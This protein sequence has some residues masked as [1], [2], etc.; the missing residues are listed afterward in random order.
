MTTNVVDEP[1]TIITKR[2]EFRKRN[3][4]RYEKCLK[5]RNDE[6]R[7]KHTKKRFNKT[8][9]PIAKPN[10]NTT[11]HMHQCI[12]RFF[13]QQSNIHTHYIICSH[14]RETS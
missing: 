7:S 5:F 10:H 4:M 13:M 3:E 14:M 2:F 12:S 9:E 11:Q 1:Y 8:L 6:K